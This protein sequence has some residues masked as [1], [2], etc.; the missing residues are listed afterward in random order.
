MSFKTGFFKAATEA[1]D[2]NQERYERYL[3]EG[4]DTARKNIPKLRE[5]EQK[6]DNMLQDIRVIKSNVIGGSG[7]SDDFFYAIVAD[8]GGTGMDI[9]TIKNNVLKSKIENQSLSADELQAMINLNGFSA[10]DN[11]SLKENLSDLFGLTIQKEKEDTGPKDDSSFLKNALFAAFQLNPKQ[12]AENYLNT[13]S[14]QG[15]PV[16]QLLMDNAGQKRRVEGIERVTT[17]EGVNVFRKDTLLPDIDAAKRRFA[18]LGNSVIEKKYKSLVFFSDNLRDFTFR[19]AEGKRFFDDNKIPTSQLKAET[20]TF[21]RKVGELYVELSEGKDSR[22][23]NNII[24][25]FNTVLREVQARELEGL[26]KKQLESDTFENNVLNALREAVTGEKNQKINASSSIENDPSVQE[27]YGFKSGQMN[28]IKI[29]DTIKGNEKNGNLKK[30]DE[31]VNGSEITETPLTKVYESAKTQYQDIRNQIVSEEDIDQDLKNILN[32]Q[33]RAKKIMHPSLEKGEYQITR[34]RGMIYLIPENKTQDAY[35]IDVNSNKIKKLPQQLDKVQIKDEEGTPI[36]QRAQKGAAG[37]A[38]T[39]SFLR[40]LLTLDDD[41][42]KFKK[43]DA[44]RFRDLRNAYQD[45]F[46]DLYNNGGNLKI[47]ASY[48]QGGLMSRR[49]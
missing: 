9:A 16:N 4:F 18:V 42:R 35:I 15:L 45:V 41:I 11:K 44:Q 32:E 3:K 38:Y 47:P 1:I 34:T 28:E 36:T 43:E 46:G 39:S 20:E 37:T 2:E 40:G 33:P 8:G 24:N 7:I 49:K 29:L 26:S 14:L 31:V 30:K 21:N 22:E 6:V 17:K 25:I 27:L 19:T 13:A 10:P 5:T 48:N 12:R 23:Q